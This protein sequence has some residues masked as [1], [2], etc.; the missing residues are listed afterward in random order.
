[1]KHLI[2]LFF[3][4]GITASLPVH[5]SETDPVGEKT[6]TR[7]YYPDGQLQAEGWA[8]GNSKTGYWK[9]YHPNGELAASGHFR[10]NKKDRYW[11]YY[12]TNGELIKEGHYRNAIAEDWWIFYDL[13]ESKMVKIQFKGN[14]KHGYA[15][16]YKKRKLIKV[17][18]FSNDEKT[19]EWTSVIAFKLD[20]PDV[21]W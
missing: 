10:N 14:R 2:L 7:E 1:M 17:E 16:R 20:N 15:L 18:R 8:A 6:Y 3:F 5:S 9:M 12:N 21:R 11:H 4:F 13:D 19:G